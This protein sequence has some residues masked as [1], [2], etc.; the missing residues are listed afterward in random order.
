MVVPANLDTLGAFSAR[1]LASEIID[2]CAR[3]VDDS[4]DDKDDEV[5]DVVEKEGRRFDILDDD[6]EEDEDGST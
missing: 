2:V 1:C 5:V 4:A 3:D 6:E